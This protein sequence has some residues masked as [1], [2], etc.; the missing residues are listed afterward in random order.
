MHIS[1]FDS[2]EDTRTTWAVHDADVMKSIKVFV[3]PSR[4]EI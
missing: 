3:L 1:K 4:A 2:P